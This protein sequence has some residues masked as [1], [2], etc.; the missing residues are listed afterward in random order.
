LSI[1]FYDNREVLNI[2]LCL[3]SSALNVNDP[4]ILTSFVTSSRYMA[5]Y[6]G[7]CL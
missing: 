5:L 1:C 7:M 4:F 2:F 6:F 3:Y